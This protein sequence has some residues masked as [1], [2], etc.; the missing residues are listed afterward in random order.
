MAI[1]VVKFP[2]EEFR[3]RYI[4]GKNQLTLRKLLYFNNKPSVES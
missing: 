3:E 4:F 2:I 1:W